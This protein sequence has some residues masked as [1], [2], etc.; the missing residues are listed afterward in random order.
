MLLI[1]LDVSTKTGWAV[2]KNG[3]LIEYGTL[4]PDKTHNDFGSYP[5]NYLLL[6]RYLSKQLMLLFESLVQKHSD[7]FSQE[8]VVVIEETN[9][10]KQ[11]YSQ[12]KLEYLHYLVNSELLV[13]GITAKYIRDGEWK[14]LTGARQNA[15]EKRLN[16]KIRS[17]KK[18]TGAKLAKIDGK[19]VGKKGKK[20]YAIRAVKEIFGIGLMRK[21]E[22]TADAILLGLGYLRGAPHCDGTPDGGK[23]PKAEK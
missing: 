18:K 3:E 22:D 15:D 23:S 8:V 9:A 4:F 10:S 5:I 6:C 13:R 19:V 14:R 1:A 16:A 7:N 17:I 12:K 20:D 2:Y 11:N 21:Q